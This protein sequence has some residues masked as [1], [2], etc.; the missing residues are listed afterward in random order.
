MKADHV[1]KNCT[2]LALFPTQCGYM[3]FYTSVLENGPGKWE[4]I[5]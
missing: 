2:K 1:V 3:N 4:V 5:V